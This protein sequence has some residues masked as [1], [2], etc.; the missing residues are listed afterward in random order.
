M[1]KE[2]HG[3]ET[4]RI[5]KLNSR[6]EWLRQLL[7]PVLCIFVVIIFVFIS[8]VRKAEGVDN[9]LIKWLLIICV[10]QMMILVSIVIL[11]AR[12]RS[13]IDSC[14]L[15]NNDEL[16][17]L[18]K[19]R[20]DELESVYKAL[21]DQFF[22]LSPDGSIIRSLGGTAP[23]ENR[24]TGKNIIE[25]IPD[26][27][28]EL[29]LC[30]LKR[31][32]AENTLITI[33]CDLVHE[34]KDTSIECRIV[35]SANNSLTCAIRNITKRKSFERNLEDSRREQE[36]LM[37][38]VHHRVKNNL[39]F[40]ISLLGLYDDP[41]GKEPNAHMQEVKDRLHTLSLIQEKMYNRELISH[42]ELNEYINDLAG[43]LVSS[44]NTGNIDLSI[45]IPQMFYSAEKL[46]PIGL[47]TTEL[48]SLILKYRPIERENTFIR[49]KLDQDD[50]HCY[51]TFNHNSVELADS[52]DFEKEENISLKLIETLTE[53][54]N[55]S[56]DLYYGEENE[57]VVLKF[58]A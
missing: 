24:I 20:T 14:H 49:I 57:T 43:Y 8:E 17:S 52:P 2:Y 12:F 22:Q 42:V 46:V 48:M 38:E 30:A 45:Q 50:E 53:Q 15:L 33:E 51:L 27:H 7:I 19:D 29:L 55:G 28:K 13:E 44:V 5:D 39:M 21:P 47:L 23:A 54:I 10:A 58:P 16:E 56:L 32:L 6:I 36:V 31:S 37:R 35:P 40:I 25:F 41:D 34:G 4:A 9:E 18:I 3:L 11:V 1:R 26:S